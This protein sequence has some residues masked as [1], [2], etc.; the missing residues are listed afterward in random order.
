VVVLIN[1]ANQ[2]NCSALEDNDKIDAVLWI[3]FPGGQGAMAVGKILNG[4][5]NPSGHLTDTYVR[6][7]K[8]N[9]SYNNFGDN[10]TTDGNRFTSGG[11]NKLYYFTDY[12][13][14][15]YVGYRYYETRGETDGDTWYNNNVV[16]PF[17]YGLSYTNF[18]WSQ[19][20]TTATTI[21][22]G[23]TFDVKVTVTNSGSVAGKDVVEIYAAAPYT[24]GGIEKSARV[25]VG[26]RKDR[27]H[28]AWQI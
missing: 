5:V 3:G 23:Q 4:T 6:D 15:V 7:F 25:L 13:E 18:T 11:K 27:H 20:T 1:A 28:R 14:G 26:F 16:Y 22:K 2:L 21:T 19:A 10:G 24:A 12:E 9:P 8:S 17:G